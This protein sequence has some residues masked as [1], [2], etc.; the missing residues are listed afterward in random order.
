MFT[1]Y[2][3]KT[4]EFNGVVKLKYVNEHIMEGVGSSLPGWSKMYNHATMISPSK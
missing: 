3:E 4:L 1:E 2:R